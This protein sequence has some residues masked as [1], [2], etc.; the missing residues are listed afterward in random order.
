MDVD[1]PPSAQF[2]FTRIA[3]S[4]VL[5]AAL[6]V[7]LAK[8]LLYNSAHTPHVGPTSAALSDAS[9]EI[10]GMC[11][12]LAIGALAAAAWVRSAPRLVSGLFVGVLA[13]VLAVVP[14]S[15]LTAPSDVSTGDKV[16]W[17]V[18]LLIPS[19][20]L[21]VA[22]AGLGAAIGIAIRGRQGSAPKPS[23]N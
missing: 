14:Y 23:A 2:D 17:I 16:A 6:A 20:I 22:G 1:P 10:A 3:I 12:G 15:W 21:V 4:T 19:L 18:I 11:L 8:A 5:T 9:S 7:G 13:F